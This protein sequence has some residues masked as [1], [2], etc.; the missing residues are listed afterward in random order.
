MTTYTPNDW[1]NGDIITDEKL[2]H[3]E[4]GI[5][6]NNAALRKIQS[7]TSIKDLGAVNAGMTRTWKETGGDYFGLLIAV[8]QD[9]EAC[10]VG[11]VAS[12]LLSGFFSPIHKGQSIDI[13]ITK[14]SSN[15]ITSHSATYPT[16]VYI[17]KL[18][19]PISAI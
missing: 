4:Q 5:D 7:I 18:D 8:S 16:Y 17:V 14:N 12:T 13:S 15:S 1:N 19:A 11:Y 6:I 2:D 10:A 3:I 9:P